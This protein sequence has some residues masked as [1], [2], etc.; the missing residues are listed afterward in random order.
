MNLA[1][2][3][4]KSAGPRVV[5][6]IPLAGHSIYWKVVAA[7]LELEKPARSDLMVFQGA[8][9]DRARNHLAQQMLDHPMK[10]THLFF[11][12]SD[13]VPEPDTLTRLLA[14]KRPIVSGVYRRRLFP[15]EPMA[16][17]KKK[18]ELSPIALRKGGGMVSVDYVG[19][20]CLLIERK[21]F[22][23]LK[24]PWFLNEWKEGRYLSEDFYFCEKAR[25][26][27]FKIEVDTSIRPLHLEP[28]GVGTDEAGEA[29]WAPVF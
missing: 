28:M 9:I 11:L 23:K 6:A 17:V 5:I 13:I 1:G 7:I 27:G 10:A 24:S 26:V 20:G 22:E 18:N 29:Q 16:F 21:V 4:V 25:E 14:H 3:T 2:S 8:L 15:H 19:G 12:D